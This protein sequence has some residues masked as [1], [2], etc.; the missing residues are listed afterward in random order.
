MNLL[1]IRAASPAQLREA[2][3]ILLD[4]LARFTSAWKTLAEAEAE[5]ATFLSEDD[6]RALLACEGEAVLGW[7]GGIAE[8]YDYAWELH[9]LVVDPTAQGRGVGTALVA[10]IE[11][12]AAEDGALTIWVGS[13]DDF[14]GTTLF[15]RDLFPD[16]LAALDRLQPTAGHPFTF[17]RRM[18]YAVCGVLPDVNGPGKPDIFLAKRVGPSP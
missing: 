8:M 2:A 9:P 17:Y 3:R 11:R 6:R 16:P 5:V 4:A 7:V 14:G 13:D 15:G 1:D 12:L 18:G 10:A